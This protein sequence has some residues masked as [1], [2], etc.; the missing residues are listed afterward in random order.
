MVDVFNSEFLK[1]YNHLLRFILAIML[2]SVAYYYSTGFHNVWILT[3]LAPIPLCLY[4]LE[5]SLISTISASFIAY[6]IGTLNQFGYLPIPIY[7]VSNVTSATIFTFTLVMFRY[8]AIQNRYWVSSFIFASG[9]TGYEFLMSL[10]S[11]YGTFNSIAYTQIENLP[12][13]QI[14]AITGIWGISFL[15]SLIPASVAL[16]WDNRGNPIKSLKVSAISVS[17]LALALLFGFYRLS[18]PLEDSSIKIGIA[19]VPTTIEQIAS[20]DTNKVLDI[21]QRYAAS[22][23]SLADLGATVVLLPEK[24]A[25]L[26]PDNQRI[27]L[28]QLKNV[29]LKNNVT[30]IAGLTNRGDKIYNSAYIF[31]PDGE[32][33]LKYDKQHLLPAYEGRYTSGNALGV[34]ETQLTGIWGVEICKDMDF[35]RP[36]LDYSSQG[37][38]VMFVPA[39]DFHEDGWLHGRIGIMRGVEGNYAV[40]RA[41]QWGLL[42]LSDSN[43]RIIAIEPTDASLNETLLIGELKLGSGKSIYSQLGDWFGWVCIMFFGIWFM[44]ALWQLLTTTNSTLKKELKDD[45]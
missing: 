41:A 30:L 21:I 8:F 25:T 20:Q 33:L 43:G 14:S 34:V 24:I 29:A 42:T 26:T 40:A 31:S 28:N 9:W 15:L 10:Y 35:I 23:E 11:S 38:N 1:K 19:T 36:S 17:L 32:S 27:V 18:V 3:W 39:L 7:L 44:I 5:T 16:T 4:S 22:V 6:F 2:S 37:I 12:I 13:I 45:M